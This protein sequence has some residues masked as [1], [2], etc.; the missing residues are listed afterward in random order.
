[1]RFVL[2][3]DMN[4]N[5]ELCRNAS[6]SLELVT[7]YSTYIGVVDL[8]IQHWPTIYTLPIQALVL[9][10]LRSGIIDLRYIMPIFC[11][12]LFTALVKVMGSVCCTA[13]NSS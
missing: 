8:S 4:S 10:T 3:A 13:C 9:R 11:G 6:F 2:S 1:M 7:I 5:L 12:L